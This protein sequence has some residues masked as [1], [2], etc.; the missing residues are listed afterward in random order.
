MD[1]LEQSIRQ[2]VSDALKD[3]NNQPEIPASTGNLGVFSDIND[4][5]LAAEI[6]FKEYIELPLDTRIKIIANIR[7]VSHEQNKIMSKKGVPVIDLYTFTK[8][9]TPNG[10]IDHVHYRGNVR[11]Q[12]ADF[13]SGNIVII[14][15]K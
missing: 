11:Q 6:A 5:V 7:K 10:Y 14:L 8:K 9:F 13:I 3:I 15:N 2:L 1:N 4:A 12:Q